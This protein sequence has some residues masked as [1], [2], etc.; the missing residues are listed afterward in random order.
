MCRNKG[1]RIWCADANKPVQMWVKQK[2]EQSIE[3]YRCY[4]L[5][6]EFI[7]EVSKMLYKKNYAKSNG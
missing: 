7:R 3:I 5:Q 2:I 4:T 1:E 6:I